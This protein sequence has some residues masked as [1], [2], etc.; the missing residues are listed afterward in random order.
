[1][2]CACLLVLCLTQT[3]TCDTAQTITQP[4]ENT[5]AALGTNATFSCRGT[6]SVLWQINGTQVRD[7]SQPQVPA[8]E[9]IQVF[10]PPPRDSSSELIVTATRVTNATLVIICHVDPGFEMGDPI[11]SAAV[12]LLVYGMSVP[13]LC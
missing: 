10:V 11:M 2:Q 1:M 13:M 6:G 3:Y 7:A 4:P 5:T 9:R 8:F 12:H